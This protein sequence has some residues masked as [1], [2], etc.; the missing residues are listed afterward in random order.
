M[1][2]LKVS[3]KLKGKARNTILW[4]CEELD[5]QPAG[6]VRMC[7]SDK[8]TSMLGCPPSIT[9]GTPN[10]IT[11]E[12]A[13]VSP[14]GHQPRAHTGVAKDLS[15]D[16][17]NSS[18]DLSREFF[19]SFIG[20]IEFV[21]FPERVSKEIKNQWKAILESKLT[22]AEMAEAYNQYVTDS[23][24]NNNKFSHPNSWIAGHGWEN[25][26][27]GYNGKPTGNYDF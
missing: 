18:K 27:G 2:E 12:S 3:I 15:L 9:V 14:E 11:A 19:K 24:A 25:S 26:N 7:V 16:K 17:S 20:K 1:D 23:K 4:L 5:M 10:T 13:Q 21:Q 8:I 22:P 6:V